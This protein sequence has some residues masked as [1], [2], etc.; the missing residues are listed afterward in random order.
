[1]IT[2]EKFPITAKLVITPRIII[3]KFQ[4]VVLWRILNGP[5]TTTFYSLPAIMR[6]RRNNIYASIAFK[7]TKVIQKVLTVH[8]HKE[9][10]KT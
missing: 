6:K 2:I 5:K 9:K 4:R 7:V 10:G 8:S 3:L 1:M